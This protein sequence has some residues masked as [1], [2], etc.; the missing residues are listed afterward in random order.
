MKRKQLVGMAM[1]AVMISVVFVWTSPVAAGDKIVW[2]AQQGAAAGS[3]QHESLTRLAKRIN[4]SSGGR[5]EI[6]AYPGGAIAAG[7]KEFDAVHSGIIDLAGDASAWW[8]NKWPSADLF[9]YRVGGL[10]AMET[11]V[12]NINGGGLELVR[13][14]VKD[15]NVHVLPAYFTP[16]EAFLSSTKPINSVSDLKGLR[17]RTA[18]GGIDGIAFKGMGAAIVSVPAPEIY[19]SVQRGVIDAFQ[20]GPPAVDY[21][22]STYEVIKY[23]YLSPVRQPTDFYYYLIN[24]KSWNALPKDLQA[25]VEHECLVEGLN[26]F[27]SLTRDDAI[28]IEGYKKRGV[29]VEPMSKDVEELL[30]KQ[31]SKIYGEKANKDA[32]TA[33]VLN[34]QDEFLKK[35]RSLY[36]RF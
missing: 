3:K 11:L 24:T 25:L 36:Q 6:K 31:A 32:F 8:T 17:I 12:W 14:M 1:V 5:L 4:L 2:K 21:A 22:G 34:S 18:G 29:I 35:V 20:W 33:E 10:S 19:E 26:Y 16:P 28:A 23:M 7:G 15:Y 30:L 13:K 27:S 9:N